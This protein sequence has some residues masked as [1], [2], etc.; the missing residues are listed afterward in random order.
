MHRLFAL[1]LMILLGAPSAALSQD[2]ASHRIESWSQAKVIAM[3]REIFRQ[4]RAAWLAA[5]VL[6]AARQ[7][8]ELADVRGWIVVPTAD[9]DLVRFLAADETGVR[10][11]W[12]IPVGPNGAGAAVEAATPDLSAEEQARWAARQTAIANADPMRCGPNLNSVVAR[13]PDSDGWLVW[14]LT[15]TT[16]NGILPIGGHQRF[17]ISADGQTVLSRERLSVGC[18]NISKSVPE[19]ADE[20]SALAFVNHLVSTGPVE[21]HVFL[22][23]LHQTP[24]A[25]GVGDRVFLVMGDRLEEHEMPRQR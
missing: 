17:R 18:L 13:D 15:A 23:L 2:A 14:L 9:G 19:G 3:G 24:I 22:S 11:R 20:G 4:D 5:D 25:V 8:S 6:L 21:T 7:Q 10:A 12:D 16:E 1:A